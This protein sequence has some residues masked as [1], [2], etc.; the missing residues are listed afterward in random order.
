LSG[1]FLLAN[2][3]VMAGSALVVGGAIAGFLPYN[4]FPARMFFGDTGA[5]AIGFCLGAFAL[6]GGATLSAGFA[7]ILP[8]FVLGMPIAETL[9]SM[10]RRAVRRLEQR[11]A[12][13]IFDADRNHMHHRLL[14]LGIDHPRAVLILYGAGAVFAAV[15]LLSTLLSAGNSALLVVALL[16]AGSLGVQRLGYDEFAIIRNGM[17]LR[18]YDAPVLNKSMFAVFLDVVIVAVAAVLAVGLKTD[19]NLMAHRAEALGMITALAPVTIVV[20]WRMGLYRGTWRLAGVDDFMRASCGVLVASLLGMTLR[21][22]LTLSEPSVSLFAIYTLAAAIL[23]TGARAS[24]QIL[25]AS[26]W[27]E[28]RTGVPTLIYG[29]GRKGAT[30]LRELVAHPSAALRPVAFIDDDVAKDGRLVNGIPIVGSIKSIER[31]IRRFAVR[32][33]VVACD[34]LPEPR[35]AQL[36]ELCERSGVALLKMRVSLDSVGEGGDA[37]SA[38]A[39]LAVWSSQASVA[40]AEPER[41]PPRVRFEDAR[42]SQLPVPAV[43]SERCPGCGSYR[44]HRSHVRKI[45]ERV[46][47]HLTEKRLFRCDSC[48]WRGWNDIIDHAAYGPFPIPAEPISVRVTSAAIR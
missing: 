7:A 5:T 17:V 33:V 18:A 45:S 9:I 15:A 3:P 11:D 35:L 14:A 21:M 32:A 36:G 16:L 28:A 25:A 46:R 22:A 47:K 27:R 20:F 34:A 6:A 12:G 41:V 38:A 39:A 43:A 37:V 42:S 8:V 31:A 44:L 48:G 19:W 29:A 2:E 23:V 10:A 4:I 24:Y 40:A 13:G 26:R 1:V 30:A